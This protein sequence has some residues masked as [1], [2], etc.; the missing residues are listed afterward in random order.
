MV[1]PAEKRSAVAHL[2]ATHGMSERRACE[3]TGYCRMTV[4]YETTPPGQS[5][6]ETPASSNVAMPE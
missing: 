1:T 2:V 3:A 4:R 6:F 5:L